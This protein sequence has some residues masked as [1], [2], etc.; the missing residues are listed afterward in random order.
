MEQKEK[1]KDQTEGLMYLEN[2]AEMLWS[3]IKTSC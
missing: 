2:P 1:Q 3:I